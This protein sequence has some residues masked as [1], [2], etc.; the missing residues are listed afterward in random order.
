MTTKKKSNAMKFLDKSIGKVMSFGSN[1]E[2]IRLADDCTQSEFAKLLGIS[3]VHLCQ[4]EKGVKSVSPERAKA[5][6]KN[7][8]YSELSF[9]ELAVQDLLDRSGIK[10]KVMLKAA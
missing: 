7:L 9:I 3:Q 2:A 10:A 5:F 6:A 8:G 1:L 4:I